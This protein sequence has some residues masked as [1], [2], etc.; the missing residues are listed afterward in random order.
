MKDL[1]PGLNNEEWLIEEK[2]WVPENQNLQETLLSTGNGF[3]G[4]RGVLEEIPEGSYAGTYF[5]GLYDSC[6]TQV[7]EL[8]NTPNPVYFRITLCANM[9]E[10]LTTQ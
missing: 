10:T 7:T 3:L 1:I 5:A 6:N 8:V 2:K 4:S 9:S